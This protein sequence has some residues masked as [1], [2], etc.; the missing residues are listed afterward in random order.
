M[1]TWRLQITPIHKTA[2]PVAIQQ[3]RVVVQRSEEPLNE[4]PGPRE[5]SGAEG[6]TRDECSPE[7]G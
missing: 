2:L 1:T 4:A 6:G 3:K 7:T 5:H